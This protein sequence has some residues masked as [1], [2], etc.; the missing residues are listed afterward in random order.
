M[1]VNFLYAVDNSRKWRYIF[2][3]IFEIFDGRKVQNHIRKKAKI[4]TSLEYVSSR[5]QN[6]FDIYFTLDKLNIF[7]A[8]T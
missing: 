6:T 2:G 4:N 5:I 3:G 8:K 1:H 7:F